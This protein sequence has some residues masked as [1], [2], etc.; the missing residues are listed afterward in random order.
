MRNILLI[1]A[2]LFLNVA[3]AQTTVKLNGNIYE[4]VKVERDAGGV[5]T[6]KTFK[7]LPVMQ[8]KNGK[9][10]IVKTSKKTNR[11]YKQYLKVN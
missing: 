3:T 9:L 4:P 5:A 7:G 10:Y 1:A 2:L 11:Q 8:S 6:G